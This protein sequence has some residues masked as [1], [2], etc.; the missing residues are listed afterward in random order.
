M[1]V[2]IVEDDA[3]YAKRM[4]DFLSRYAKEHDCAFSVSKYSSGDAF[5]FDCRKR[6]DIV[7]MDIDMPGL[8]GIETA[9]R[10]REYDETV[11]LIFVTNLT[12]FALKGYEVS[13]K[14]YIVKPLEYFDFAFKME[15]AVW[16]CAEREAKIF[17]DKS[18]GG[19]ALKAYDVYYVESI[20]HKLVY[21]TRLG[22][23]FVWNKSLKDLEKL[24]EYK[25]FLRSS[26]SYFVNLA[27]VKDINGNEVTV[28][29]EK[30]PVSR[31]KKKAFIEGCKEF[32]RAGRLN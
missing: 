24:P 12:Q 1:N 8:N 13:A 2:A 4:E 19:Y 26:E 15:K 16:Q 23:V 29:S 30:L 9:K 32:L 27:H 20:G 28:A 31:S 6:F 18:D 3:E 17:I 10:M 22:N 7:F 21:H 5:L 25:N 14:Y 11:C